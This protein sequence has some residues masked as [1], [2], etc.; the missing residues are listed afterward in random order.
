MARQR[1][2]EQVLSERLYV[3]VTKAEKDEISASAEQK[4]LTVS[5]YLRLL[6]FRRLPK[7]KLQRL[8]LVDD[9]LVAELARQ[10]GNFRSL[11]KE[12]DRTGVFDSVRSAQILDKIEAALKVVIE[13]HRRYL[14][15]LEQ[16]QKNDRQ[17]HPQT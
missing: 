10:G 17:G 15:G 5:D 6:I 9:K 8:K 1:P 14:A 4:G 12:Y 16:E 13:T 2:A 7:H 11:Y 3:R